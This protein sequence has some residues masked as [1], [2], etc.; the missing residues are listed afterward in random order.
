V[1]ELHGVHLLGVILNRASSKVPKSILRR[2][3]GA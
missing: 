3:P 1:E 2:L